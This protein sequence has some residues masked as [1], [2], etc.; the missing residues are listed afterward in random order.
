MKNNTVTI[1][2]N[3]KE[4]KEGL[5]KNYIDED[6]LLYELDFVKHSVEMGDLDEL[7]LEDG[8]SVKI[9]DRTVIKLK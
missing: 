9:S 2:I 8:G 1:T 5:Y 7:E 3:A 6:A 4:I